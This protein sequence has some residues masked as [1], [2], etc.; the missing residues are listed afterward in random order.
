MNDKN[1]PFGIASM[2]CGILSICLW[3]T[4]T[5]PIFVGSLG[6]L[7]ALLSHRKHQKMEIMSKVGLS[8]SCVG[9]LLGIMLTTFAVKDMMDPENRAQINAIYENLY[10]ESFDDMLRDSISNSF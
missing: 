5:L 10:G 4:G 8:L 3:C 9:I 2:V 7:F 1:S 6:I